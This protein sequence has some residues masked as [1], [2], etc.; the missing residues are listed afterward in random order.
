[1]YS[2]EVRQHTV[3]RRDVKPAN[4]RLQAISTNRLCSISG[5]ATG[6]GCAH[7]AI[8]SHFNVISMSVVLTAASD[9]LLYVFGPSVVPGSRTL[10]KAEFFYVSTLPFTDQTQLTQISSLVCLF[11]CLISL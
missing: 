10:G 5:A 1:M 2:V 6:F 11:L 4:L 8:L 9:L 7:T 3:Y